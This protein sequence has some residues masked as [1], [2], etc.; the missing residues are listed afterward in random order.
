MPPESADAMASPLADRALATITAQP[1]GPSMRTRG[2]LQHTCGRWGASQSWTRNW[3]R[4][5]SN[6]A[7]LRSVHRPAKRPIFRTRRDEMGQRGLGVGAFANRRL[8]SA[9]SPYRYF[10]HLTRTAEPQTSEPGFCDPIATRAC[11]F[12]D[13]GC[14]GDCGRLGIL[15]VEQ[16]SRE[17]QR[18][19]R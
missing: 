3:T 15:V 18:D 14:P 5:A 11:Q 6:Q 1:P 13:Q 19:R 7:I 17:R 9:T 2:R 8:L 16:V 10:K 4:T 12:T